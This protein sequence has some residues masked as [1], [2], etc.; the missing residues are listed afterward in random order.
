[1]IEDN[2]VFMLFAY[3]EFSVREAQE[4]DRDAIW[5]WRNSAVVRAWMGNSA[6]IAHEDH[7]RWFARR[8]ETRTGIFILYWDERPI[9]VFTFRPDPNEPSTR[10]MTMYL[11]EQYQNAGLGIV[12]EWFMLERA[13]SD[14]EFAGVAGILFED[15]QVLSL[16]RFFQFDVAP[17]EDDFL[18]ISMDRRRYQVIAPA[19][20]SKIFRG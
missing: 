14:P 9:G 3:N 18:R 15:N 13:F 6:E 5:N 1:M 11:I 17:A 4:S 7:I 16:H 12:L 8:R 20:K 19:I 10:L 2:G